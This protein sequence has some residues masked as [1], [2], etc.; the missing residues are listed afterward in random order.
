I[1]S[2]RQYGRAED[3]TMEAAIEQTRAFAAALAGVAP[4]QATVPASGAA[5]LTR[6][7]AGI[8]HADFASNGVTL[9]AVLDT[10]AGFSTI[11]ETNAAR[12]G[13]HRLDAAVTVGNAAQQDIATHLAVADRLQ[14][15]GAE[16]RNVV[17]I[18]VPDAALSFAGGAYKIEAIV[19]FPVLMQ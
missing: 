17:F 1:V 2:S 16:Y 13:L 6:D 3:A 15:A 8:M 11:T 7:M 18:V 10:G 4:M 5:P 9:S 19:G 12:L 14:F